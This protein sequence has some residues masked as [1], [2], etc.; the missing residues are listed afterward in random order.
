MVKYLKLI[1]AILGLSFASAGMASVVAAKKDDVSVLKDAS[2]KAS[3]LTK[4]KKGEE[5]QAI[6]R[7]GMYWK[8][9]YEAGE[10]YV[11]VLKVR[12]KA[13]GSKSLSKAIRA[14]AQQARTTDEVQGTRAR[15]AVMGVRGLSDSDTVASAGNVSPNLRV[16]YQME[17]DVVSDAQIEEL[18]DAIF[19]EVEK[20]AETR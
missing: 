5:L 9:K 3:V 14:A 8:V 15:S 7:K 10:G 12:R 6:E 2:R 11:S 20:R 1:S 16:I 17:D 18:G 19:S 4:L 13:S